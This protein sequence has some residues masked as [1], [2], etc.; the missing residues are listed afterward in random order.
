MPFSRPLGRHL[1]RVRPPRGVWHGCPSR[2]SLSR[3][4]RVL[5][6]FV[7]ARRAGSAVGGKSGCRH[8]RLRGAP[9]GPSTTAEDASRVEGGVPV[10]AQPLPPFRPSR[11]N[12]TTA[13]SGKSL[14]NKKVAPCPPTPQQKSPFFPG[15][16]FEVAV[17]GFFE[18]ATFPGYEAGPSYPGLLPPRV[19]QIG[20][21]ATG[22]P[23]RRQPGRGVA[24]PA[25]WTRSLGPALGSASSVISTAAAVV[26]VAAVGPRGARD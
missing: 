23:G 1:A 13:R 17:Q 21:I 25:R 6:F 8:R 26:T 19:P 4:G 14:G 3:Q 15:A 7:A 5:F 16:F 2:T 12:S 9:Q 22:L 18:P 10:P 20:T 11:K 24:S